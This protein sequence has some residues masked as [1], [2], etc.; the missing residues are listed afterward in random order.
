MKFNSLPAASRAK[1]NTGNILA[2][3]KRFIAFIAPPVLIA[4]MYPIFHLL[5]KIIEN[6]TISW[7]LGLAIYCMIWG[8]IFPYFILGKDK[9]K[10]MI[11]PQRPTLKLLLFISVI[12]F[13][14]LAARLF[15][16]GMS[17]YEK[18][19]PLT[20][21]LVLSTTVCNGFFEELLWRGIYVKLFPD[22]I[23][24]WLI[25]PGIWFGIWHY[26]PVSIHSDS[27]SGLIGMILG[28]ATM[29][30]Y[31]AYLT[32]KTNTLFWAIAAHTIGGI[33][34]VS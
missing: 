18:E 10:H 24:Y 22:K 26:V 11:R 30:L 7:Y 3:K 8:A 34:M 32:K 12:L 14:S 1:S 20:L 2:D 17:G 16:P 15:V 23:F 28:S 25:W 13:G 4:V 5:S 27:F 9:I 6:D 33:I 21:V 31:L 19:S 29:G